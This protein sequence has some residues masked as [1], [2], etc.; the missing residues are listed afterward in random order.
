VSPEAVRCRSVL[1]PLTR[2]DGHGCAF[3]PTCSWRAPSAALPGSPGRST[4]ARK[5]ARL[6]AVV[7]RVAPAVTQPSAS[8]ALAGWRRDRH[9]PLLPPPLPRGTYCAVLGVLACYGL[10]R[11]ALLLLWL[12]T[13]R[14]RA[15]LPAGAAWLIVTVQLPLYNERYVAER[16]LRAVGE[17]DYPHDRLEVQVLDDSNDDTA[18]LVASVVAQLA[19]GGLE[20]HHLRR[21]ERRGYKA[22]A[23]AA[24]LARARGE[25]LCVFDADFVPAPDFLRRT[26]PWFADPCVGM[27]QAR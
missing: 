10:H 18:A 13:R 12:R 17:L 20:I 11:A 19:A 3:S 14:A 8:D 5:L 26:V 25:L 9:W 1:S 23:L 6:P 16:L 24:G 21:G 22:G 15:V 7:Q 4:L 27:V 2:L